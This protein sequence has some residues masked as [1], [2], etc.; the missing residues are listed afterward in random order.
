MSASD[1]HIGLVQFDVSWERPDLNMQRVESLVGDQSNFDLLL[2]P[3]MWS[4]GFSMAPETASEPV[5]GP[6]LQW[7]LEK[8]EQWQTAIAGSIAVKDGAS[9]YNRFYCTWPDGQTA[10]YDKKHLFSYG[11]EDQHYSPGQNRIQLEVKGWK[12]RPIICYDLRFPVW[13]RNQDG[14]D[15]L[16]VVAN[17]PVPRIQHW[18]A[19]LMARA[20]E[21]QCFVAAVNRIGT[22]ANG[23]EYSGHSSV[24]AMNGLLGIRMQTK[25]E[26][27]RLSLDKNELITYRNQ[28][29]FLQDQDTFTI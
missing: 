8:A 7:M 5:G 2:L 19:L 20:I 10:Q 23:L 11:K 29:R 26:V 12:I 9:Y 17:W 15:L 6:A 28:F 3:E 18:D 27:G 24:Y 16:V 14:Y 1:L 22:D 25:E 4:S 21:N 13:C